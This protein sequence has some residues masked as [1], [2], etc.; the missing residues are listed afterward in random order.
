[1]VG[2]QR[3][4]E[5]IRTAPDGAKNATLNKAAYSIGGLVSAGALSQGEAFAELSAALQA[6]LPYCKDK[7][8]A[9]NTLRKAFQDGMGR[10]RDVPEPP[11][12][13]EGPHPA[14]ELLAKLAAGLCQEGRAAKAY[15]GVAGHHER[16][17]RAPDDHG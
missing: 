10:P 3:E 11:P 7:R 2:L 15:A 1:M 8:A 12:V 13:D 5:A 4:C 17:R 16:G 9:E 6:I 14:A